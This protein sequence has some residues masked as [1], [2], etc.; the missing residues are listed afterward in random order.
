MPTSSSQDDRAFMDRALGLAGAQLG[1]VA[2]NPAVGCVIV[3]DG[4]IAGEGAT[5]DGGRPHAEE[6]ALDAAGDKARGAVVYVTLE[7][8]AVRTSGADA[9][10]DR[11]VDAGVERVVVACEDPHPFSDGDGV[12]RLRGAG[13]QVDVGLRRREAE[14]LNAGFFLVV[15]ESRPFVAIDPDPASYDAE[16]D[17]D[18]QANLV[19]ELRRLAVDGLTRVCAAPGTPLAGALRDAGLADLESAET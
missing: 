4:A 7:P 17:L 14:A 9:C 19:A 5:A 2:P 13:V 12:A 16:L 11:L 18:P 8:C 1:K 6:V 10:A 3:H 15:R